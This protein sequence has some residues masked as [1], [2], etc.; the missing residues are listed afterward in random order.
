MPGWVLYIEVIWS[1]DT[2]VAKR[3]SASTHSLTLNTAAW[4]AAGGGDEKD[5]NRGGG[6]DDRDTVAEV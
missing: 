5:D 2:R 6:G 1:Q 4:T 3:A